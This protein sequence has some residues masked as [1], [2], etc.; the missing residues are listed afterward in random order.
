MFDTQAGGDRSLSS[1]RRL[2]VLHLVTGHSSEQR[3]S[4]KI[5]NRRKLAE[6]DDRTRIEPPIWHRRS[7]GFLP[8]VVDE[9]DKYDPR[10]RRDDRLVARIMLWYVVSTIR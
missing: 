3:G 2:V 10:S 7:P 9:M 1:F 8:F 6:V 5:V 4:C